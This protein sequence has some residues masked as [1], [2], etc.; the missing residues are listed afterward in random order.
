MTASALVK[1]AVPE[2]VFGTSPQLAMAAEFEHRSSAVHPR[3][4]E[5]TH[6][7]Q[8]AGRHSA[9][10]AYQHLYIATPSSLASYAATGGQEHGRSHR[11]KHFHHHF[12]TALLEAH[13]H[14]RR[15]LLEEGRYGRRELPAIKK[16]ERA[17]SAEEESLTNELPPCSSPGPSPSL[18][19][20]ADRPEQ[21][22]WTKLDVLSN[23]CSAVLHDNCENSS[24]GEE[25]TVQADSPAVPAK[26]EVRAGSSEPDKR[27]PGPSISTDD[28]AEESAGSGADAQTAAPSTKAA[29]EPPHLVPFEIPVI[30]GSRGHRAGASAPSFASLFGPHPTLHSDQCSNSA[31]PQH[32]A[33]YL[34]TSPA[35]VPLLPTVYPELTHLHMHPAHPHLPLSF[36]DYRH[37]RGPAA[38][39]PALYPHHVPHLQTSAFRRHWDYACEEGYEEAT[40]LMNRYT[41]VGDVDVDDPSENGRCA[42]IEF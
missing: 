38:G 33:N 11:S 42:W 2:S 10:P 30:S 31:G 16:N 23:L 25:H 9:Y 19:A 13:D 37:H 18:E 15:P 40:A 36:I 4:K 32:S 35:A 12:P 21:T 7:H 29:K 14:Q 41:E 22:D 28:N 8:E 20:P 5:Q 27:E 24:D 1:S 17:S 26:S 34:A 3:H 39:P 6:K